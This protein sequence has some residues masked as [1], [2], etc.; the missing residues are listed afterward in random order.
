MRVGSAPYWRLVGLYVLLLF[1]VQPFLGLGID[2]FKER[3][4]EAALAW[5]V[6][7][8]AGLAAAAGLA[9][10]ARVWRAA[11]RL[12]RL[13]LAI[14]LAA[15]GAGVLELEIP[16]ER[17]HYLEYG[18][19]AAL[20]YVGSTARRPAGSWRPVAF[21]FAVAAALGL[22]DEA[23]QGWLW[24]RRYFDWRDVLLNARAAAVGLVLAVPAWR[25][26]CRRAVGP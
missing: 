2:A 8:A 13:V 3:W 7:V 12:E 17:L 9:G 22:L 14:G 16:Q 4:G 1:G 26:W 19:L 6:W 23:L 11:T 25:A 18:L 24:P 20:V 15:Y 5:T 10:L 21:G